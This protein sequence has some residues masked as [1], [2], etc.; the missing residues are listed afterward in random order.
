MKALGTGKTITGAILMCIA[1]VLKYYEVNIDIVTIV[2]TVG[3]SLGLWG[4]GHKIE[5]VA[6]ALKR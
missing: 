4:I 3:G 2:G 1:A 5:R 6:E